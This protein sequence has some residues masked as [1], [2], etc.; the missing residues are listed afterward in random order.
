MSN[1]SHEVKF[2]DL[3]ESDSGDSV[4]L[5]A[6][7]WLLRKWRNL[8]DIAD[9]QRPLL[10]LAVVFRSVHGVVLPED[11][12]QSDFGFV[13]E[14][15]LGELQPIVFGVEVVEEVAVLA[16]E[17]GDLVVHGALPRRLVGW[18]PKCKRR[19]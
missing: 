17:D 10:E 3:V 18:L 12:F 6:Q 7:A 9:R 2:G 5:C 1:R 14:V 15:R 19:L 4:E 8:Y 13:G 11:R 16:M